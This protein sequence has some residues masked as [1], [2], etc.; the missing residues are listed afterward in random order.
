MTVKKEEEEGYT[1]AIKDEEL[2]DQAMEDAIAG[3]IKTDSAAIYGGEAG[4]EERDAAHQVPG[5]QHH[6][7]G[8]D[9][10]PNHQ[11]P[12]DHA[13]FAQYH[14]HQYGGDQG[15]ASYFSDYMNQF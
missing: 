6:L 1:A 9:Q 13:L 2:D 8:F 11:G 15:N 12:V 14:Q 10:T 4:D 7:Q 3:Q 5:H